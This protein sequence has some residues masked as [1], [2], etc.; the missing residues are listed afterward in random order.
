MPFPG[1]TVSHASLVLRDMDAEAR[2][3]QIYEKSRPATVSGCYQ[4]A[5]RYHLQV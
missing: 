5:G 4:L 1:R 2:V 3:Q